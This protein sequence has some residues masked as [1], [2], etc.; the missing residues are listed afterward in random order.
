MNLKLL[1]YENNR[2]NPYGQSE[3]RE[4]SKGNRSCKRYKKN[5]FINI[6]EGVLILNNISKLDTLQQ[7]QMDLIEQ[8]YLSAVANGDVDAMFYLGM[9][10][11][12]QQNIGL[13][14]TYFLKA[15]NKGNVDAMYNLGMMCYKEQHLDLAKKYLSLALTNGHLSAKRQLDALF[16]IY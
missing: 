16:M 15:I 1:N 6:L 4:K 12:D 11:Y 13:A 9:L 8:S 5:D 2:Q 14:E 7:L 3:T 10:Y